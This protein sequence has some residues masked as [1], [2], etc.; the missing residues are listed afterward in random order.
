MT[1]D[2][3]APCVVAEL[4][5][6]LGRIDDVGEQDRRQ[7]TFVAERRRDAGHELLDLRDHLFRARRPGRTRARFPR[8]PRTELPRCARPDRVQRSTSATGSF[9]R[10]IT[11]VG[12]WMLGRTPR[13]SMSRFI[14]SRAA[15][16]PGVV[17]DSPQPAHAIHQFVGQAGV[18]ASSGSEEVRVGHPVLGKVLD[19][20]ELMLD[21]LAPRVVIPADPRGLGAPQDESGRSIGIRGRED[22]R[23]AA[24]LGCA[25]DERALAAG[26]IH[27]GTDVVGSLLEGR[28]AGRT[29]AHARPSLVEPDQSRERAE[30]LDERR[31]SQHIPEQLHV[32]H[33]AR[34]VHE[35][36]AVALARDLV[37]GLCRTSILNDA[38]RWTTVVLRRSCRS[39]TSSSWPWPGNAHPSRRSALDSRHRSGWTWWSP[40]AIPRGGAA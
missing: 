21:R 1:L 22:A 23:H 16:A 39:P 5:R 35:I 4:R 31:G 40:N 11:R 37:G 6:L 26:G 29:V 27:D 34:G 33:R 15:R 36:D 17:A 12:T 38:G 9:V 30:A 3:I 28:G 25:E 13:M 18:A 24:A 10:F 2:E 19:H 14:R 7:G 8:T 20:G 32:R